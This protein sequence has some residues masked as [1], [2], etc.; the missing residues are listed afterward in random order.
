MPEWAAIPFSSGSS[1]SRDQTRVSCDSGITGTVPTDE[2]AG[3][4]IIA[5]MCALTCERWFEQRQNPGW[6]LLP[7]GGFRH[8]FSLSPGLL[9]RMLIL[10]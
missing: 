6:K 2:P 10:P 1:P 8:G 3:K 4:L 5:G 7:L 9:L